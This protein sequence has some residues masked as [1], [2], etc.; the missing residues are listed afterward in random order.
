[1][2]TTDVNAIFDKDGRGQQHMSTPPITRMDVDNICVNANTDKDGCGQHMSTP[3][4]TR[5]DVD[6]T[7][8]HHH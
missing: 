2:W 7:C 1:M 4:L 6:N 5:M 8:Q 3:P